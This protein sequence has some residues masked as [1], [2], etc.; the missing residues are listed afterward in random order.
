VVTSDPVPDSELP[1]PSSSFLTVPIF[2]PSVREST[3]APPVLSDSAAADS[4]PDAAP[5]R[6]KRRGARE[7]ARLGS[8]AAAALRAAIMLAGGREVCF[9]AQLDGEGVVGSARAVARG[10]ARSVLALP[11]AAQRGEMLLHNH[12]SGDLEPSDADLEVAARLHD[13]GIG[14]GII[15]NA[16]R[17][18][19]VVV[20]IPRSRETVQVAAEEV[21]AVLGP[22]GPVARALATYEDRRSQ[23]AMAYRIARLY[24][25]GGIGLLEAGTGVGK[26]LGYL[27]PALRW[28]AANGE[29]TV[30][31]TNTINLQE[32]LAGKDLPFL[33]GAL[34]DQPVRWALL[35]GWRNYLCLQR[36]EQAESSGGELFD[37]G[38]AAELAALRAWAGRTTDGS[39]GDLPAPPR[40]E[41]WDEVAAEADLCGRL[42]CPYFDKCFVFAARRRAAEADVVVVNHHLLLADIAVRRAQGNWTEAAVLPAYT[43][44]VVDEGHHLEEV[45]AHHLGAS[46][47]RLALQRLFNRLERRGKGLL[48]TLAARLRARADLL[49]TASL[50]LVD[51]RLEPSLLAARDT[52]GRVFDM[53]A[54]LLPPGGDPVL[55]LTDA[56]RTHPIWKGGL[57][58]SVTDL[59][60]ELD[61]LSEG[62]RL[63]RVRLETDSARAEQLAPVLGEIAAVIRRLA[64]AGDALSTALRG[65]ASGPPLVRWIE[66]RGREQNIAAT[67][68][69]LDIAPV[70]REDLWARVK[71]AIVTSA[72]LAGGRDFSFI[73]RQLGVDEPALEPETTIFP[74]PFVFEEQAVL[75]V[76]TDIAAPNADPAAHREGVLR[77]V[78][79][80]AEIADGGLFVL[81]TSHR[82]VRHAAAAL[83]ESGAA[84]RWPLLVHGD[85]HRDLLLRR[86]RDAGRAILLGTASFWEGVDVP[87][88]ALRGLV[89][90]KLPFRVPTEP[91]TA[92]TCEAIEARGGDPFQEYMVPHATLRLKQGFGRL[93]RTRSDRGAVV[94]CDPRVVAKSY[95]RRML[96][97]LPPAR[98]MV[99]HWDEIR[100]TLA[101]FYA[102]AADAEAYAPGLDA[103]EPEWDSPDAAGDGWA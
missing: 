46:V 90:A 82:E 42:K 21:A 7:D 87:G 30:V 70:L 35:K 76:P 47:S 88:D 10:D 39:L 53:L 84:S 13:E 56:F 61:I 23:R 100:R 83:R 28:A 48:P 6:R 8:A 78:H 43:R 44:L 63:I 96:E 81:F 14:F 74:S 27:V 97:A 59:M 19:Y 60:G 75:A 65:T 11:G 86:F 94:L 3:P 41:V 16:A 36:L 102:G 58:Q 51:N 103:G 29:R 98:R 24:N 68:V 40:S 71:T 72:T 77:V 64:A 34:E 32:Q 49:S 66:R 101:A 2:D 92:A 54:L 80:L 89:L 85:E 25:G 73:V 31:S 50:D 95:G 79:D 5:G 55:R 62:L 67:A 20:E 91:I 18:L 69:P 93:I 22:A 26:S 12:P 17:E 57:E 52:G 33:A 99:G 1:G 9:V 37:G 38:T 15:D 45:A 4:V